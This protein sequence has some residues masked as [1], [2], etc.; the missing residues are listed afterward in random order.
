[1]HV[2][3]LGLADMPPLVATCVFCVVSFCFSDAMCMVFL[4]G[5][6]D[7]PPLIALCGPP[8]QLKSTDNLNSRSQQVISLVDVS[9]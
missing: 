9:R 1:M 4:I 3:L 7:R 8:H 6:V 5:F 2:V